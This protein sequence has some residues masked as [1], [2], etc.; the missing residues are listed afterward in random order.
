MTDMC[1]LRLDSREENQNPQ[2]TKGSR[3]LSGEGH[4]P[5]SRAS[6]SPY[7]GPWGTGEAK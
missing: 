1:G 3:P 2:D 4:R 5:R 7:N 6:L